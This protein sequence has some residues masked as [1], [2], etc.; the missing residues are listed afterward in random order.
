MANA[1]TDWLALEW[2]GHVP[3]EQL[4]PLLLK[5]DASLGPQ[6]NYL[7]LADGRIRRVN[8]PRSGHRVRV[9]ALRGG[10]EAD[11]AQLA[12]IDALRAAVADWNSP[13]GDQSAE[14][15]ID[16][17]EHRFLDDPA[18]SGAPSP[19]PAPE[20][21]PVAPP[22]A[23]PALERS[24]PPAAF[25]MPEPFTG[26]ATQLRAL[27]RHVINLEQGRL[28]DDGIMTTDEADL[29]TI[30]AEIARHVRDGYKLMLYAHGGLTD[31][32][33]GLASAWAYHRWWLAQKIYPVYFVWE[34][35]GLETFWQIVAGEQ[36]QGRAMP[37]DIW[38]HTTDP[39]IE[40]IAGK[41]GTLLWTGMKDSARK[42][43]EAQGGA[44]LFA[45]KLAASWPGEGGDIFAVGHSA[46]SI[47]HAHFL[48]VLCEAG[49]EVAQLH[50]LAPAITNA[51]F[52]EK[53]A[54]LIGN[55]IAA[56]SLFA[57]NRETERADNCAGLYHKSL[58]YLVSRAFEPAKDTPIL[59]ME[60][61]L[62]RDPAARALFGD[63]CNL[64]PTAP[65]PRNRASASTSH[66]GFDNDPATIES[67]VRQVMALP[68]HA[69]VSPPFPR[70]EPRIGRAIEEPNYYGVPDGL[71]RAP[72]VPAPPAQ[73]VAPMAGQ[74]DSGAGEVRLG[75]QKIALCIGNNAF[76]GGMDLYGCINDAQ[77]WAE[78]FR[79]QGYA[80]DVRSDLS[81]G[82]IRDAIRSVL[83]KARAGD[84]VLIHIS[85]HGTRVLDV[86]GDE[87]Q[88][89]QFA[90]TKDEALVA[91][92]WQAGG[93]I[94]DDEWPGLM[95]AAPGV[96]VIRFHDFCHAG[97]SARMAFADAGRRRARSVVIPDAIAR[98][99]YA[100]ATRRGA[101]EA[102]QFG[103]DLSYVTFCAC[104]PE[105]S[106]ME[107]G[108]S[109]VFTRAATRILRGQGAALSAQ[110]AFAA[111]AREMAG[112]E[113]K[114]L[115]EGSALYSAM[116]LFALP[117]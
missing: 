74:A 48:P 25:A 69:P 41:I 43:S 101:R 111:I 54:P 56:A 36:R 91:L 79:R 76:G 103:T 49:L 38:D 37:R 15:A 6:F 14:P 13:S 19:A 61:F 115:L 7:V 88:D 35:G 33:N 24:P 90:D 98:K 108:G 16:C 5:A 39:A 28:S 59:G 70:G 96:K 31:E 1:A 117:S 84:C 10:E 22:P 44:R 104:L 87:L 53:L 82:A 71:F 83:K 55:R 114:P 52:H 40:K 51:L 65:E 109:G 110:D 29:D 95:Q 85:S 47:F 32:R 11:P 64:S 73:V 86:D 66:G 106:A 67:V 17:T 23:S 93:L 8:K 89:K 72:A 50:L 9:L 107:E 81:A 80:A 30:V 4:E 105:Q 116:P 3:H 46:G 78:T 75:A 102:P 45:R 97:R 99:A 77:E 20:P 42:A 92:D 60:D 58:L 94:I 12:R 27:A 34:T 18:Q 68:D 113:Q 57:M 63:N 100:S 21:A 2:I 26:S 112:E 62:R